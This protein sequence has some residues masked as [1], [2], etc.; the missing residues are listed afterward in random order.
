MRDAYAAARHAG[1]RV[2]NPDL[3]GNN[4]QAAVERAERFRTYL[5]ETAQLPTQGQQHDPR[6]LRLA[7]RS[8]RCSAARLKH[9]AYLR[10]EPNLSC[11][12]NHSILNHDSPKKKSGY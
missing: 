12:G 11:F 2:G 9:L 7:L 10:L 6:P 4:R 8:A 1:K 5:A 3:G